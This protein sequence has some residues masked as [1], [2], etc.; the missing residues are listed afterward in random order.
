MNLA[1]AL[2]QRILAGDR[3]AWPELQ[4]LTQPTIVN[5]ARSHPGL[6][7]AGLAGLEDDV[8][9]VVVLTFARL[10]NNNFK[11]LAKFAARADSAEAP[12]QSF[13]SWLYGAVDYAIREHLR[14]R[15]GRAPRTDDGKLRLSKRDLHSQAG[16]LDTSSEAARAAFHTLQITA[17][18]TARQIFEFAA[19][20]F[21]AEELR[22]LQL[23]YLE[24]RGFEELATALG[25]GSAH[26]AERL[27]RRLNARLRYAFS[28][29]VT[30][31]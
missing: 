22:A 29:P 24:E 13:D 21:A 19:E 9:Q 25:L 10:S 6:R 2:I 8:A 26:D 28:A 16:R 3:T 14:A 17:K 5:I 1:E 27:I 20:H 18:L 30:G 15:H 11:N 7:K 31:P 12:A 4:R 23:Y